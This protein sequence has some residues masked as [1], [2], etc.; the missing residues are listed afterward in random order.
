MCAQEH[1]KAIT[2][3]SL[4]YALCAVIVSNIY[5]FQ[6]IFATPREFAL[7]NSYVVH[8]Q[9][10][11]HFEYRTCWCN[12]YK[13]IAFLKDDGFEFNWEQ[14]ASIATANNQITVRKFIAA[15]FVDLEIIYELT[16]A[17]FR[18]GYQNNVWKACGQ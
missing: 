6:H 17:Q 8:E 9:S 7:H 1:K 11:I 15:L 2:C 14:N 10:G 18:D 5:T 3:V 13:H 16:S 4:I 12:A